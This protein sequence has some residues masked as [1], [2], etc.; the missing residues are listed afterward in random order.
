MDSKSVTVYYLLGFR[1]YANFLTKLDNRTATMMIGNPTNS[2]G[3]SNAGS[4]AC[5]T[6]TSNIKNTKMLTLNTENK[7]NENKFIFFFSRM[8]NL[9]QLSGLR[10]VEL[11]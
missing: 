5:T 8:H 3:N 4:C 6:L 11:K 10:T 2:T 1:E 7:Q 9:I